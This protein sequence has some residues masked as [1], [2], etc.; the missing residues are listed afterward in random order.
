MSQW[1][2]VVDTSTGSGIGFGLS[3]SFGQQSERFLGA[4]G[5]FFFNMAKIFFLVLQDLLQSSF[6]VLTPILQFGLTQVGGGDL[7]GSGRG[8]LFGGGFG[9]D[10]LSQLLGLLSRALTSLGSADL[11]SDLGRRAHEGRWR[12]DW[13]RLADVG[14][15][16]DARHRDTRL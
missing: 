3:G 5:Q 14:E 6:H 1:P 13:R 12:V 11:A 7:G 10:L 8:G 15:T 9:E 16:A 2:V 4:A